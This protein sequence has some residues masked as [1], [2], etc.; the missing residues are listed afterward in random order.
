MSMAERGR[1]P[2]TRGPSD[3]SVQQLA[4]LSRG[5]EQK[6]PCCRRRSKIP[7]R[8]TVMRDLAAVHTIHAMPFAVAASPA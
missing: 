1:H 8:P 7:A 2:R 4:C 6:F 5:A 3:W